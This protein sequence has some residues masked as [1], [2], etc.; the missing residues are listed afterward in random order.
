M[1]LQTI[2]NE[3]ANKR[4]AMIR[5]IAADL[6]EM[7]EKAT[8]ETVKKWTVLCDKY[9]CLNT[10]ANCEIFEKRVANLYQLVKGN[11]KSLLKILY[12]YFA[13]FSPGT[14][15][16]VERFIRNHCDDNNI[17]LMEAFEQDK[18]GEEEN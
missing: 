3:V 13:K 6:E 2:T 9:N 7:A 12:V 8:D 16:G 4:R 1:I 10:L 5:K 15:V 11:E 14:F 18:E 17:E